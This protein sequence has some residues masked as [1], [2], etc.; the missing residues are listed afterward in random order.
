MP[1]S[2]SHHND[3]NLFDNYHLIRL[4]LTPQFRDLKMKWK[5]VQPD[6]SQTTKFDGI[7]NLR[8]TNL[9]K[10]TYGILHLVITTFFTHTYI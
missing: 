10:M 3:Y 5:N 9:K 1:Q 8:R 6:A 7:L 2:I 4:G